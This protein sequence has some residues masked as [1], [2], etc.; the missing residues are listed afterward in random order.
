MRNFNIHL[1]DNLVTLKTYPDNYFDSIVTDPPYGI[2]FLGKD[3][4][5]HTGTLELWKEC[6]RVLKPGGYILAFSAARTYHQLASN[7]ELAGFEIRDQLFWN[8]ASGF[9]KA[10]DIGKALQKR[11]DYYLP[12]E[13]PE[14]V[15]KEIEALL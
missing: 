9:P 2:E 12:S 5:S 6:L 15:R 13:V 1:G 10:Q 3:W 4:D 11:G 7:I 8:Y 14:D